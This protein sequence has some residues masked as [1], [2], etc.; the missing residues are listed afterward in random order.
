MRH[1]NT[2][3]KLKRE[4]GQRRALLRGLAVNLILRQ[5][6]QTT[7]SRAKALRQFI[8]PLVTLARRG[9]LAA[10]RL[11][12]ARL[13]VEDS[14]EKLFHDIA[15]KYKTRPGGYTRIIK[16]TPRQSDASPQAL[17]EFV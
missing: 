12:I 8:E 9:T 13:A 17:I 4:A 16:L 2:N 14:A 1:H 7:T 6:I 15:P 3:R 11:V 5:R 10:K